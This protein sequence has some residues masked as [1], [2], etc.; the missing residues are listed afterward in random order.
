MPGPGPRPIRI[1]AVMW[2]DWLDPRPSGNEVDDEQDDEDDA[3]NIG[4]VYG[5]ARNPAKTQN[6]GDNCQYQKY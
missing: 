3:E 4:D 2:P 5:E 1:A 6:G